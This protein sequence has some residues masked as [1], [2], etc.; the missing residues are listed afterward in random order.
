[1]N[2]GSK[3]LDPLYVPAI[4]N[5]V[6]QFNFSKTI[7]CPVQFTNDPL[8]YVES[9]IRY[10]L[11][12]VQKN[13]L[14]DLFS[15]DAE[16]TP[17]YKHAVFIGGMRGGKSVIGGVIGSF[18]LQKLLQ[19]DDP[20]TT[21]GQVPGQKFAAEFIATSEQ[22][23]KN[24]AYSAFEN[25]ILR[26]PWWKKYIAYLQEREATEGKETLF[27]CHERKLIFG[28][29]N[30]EAH[31]LHS[32]SSSIAGFTAFFV[33][34]DEMSRFD[35]GEGD[36]Q[37]KS[38]KRTAQA[39]FYTA[40]R[41]A[42]TLKKF[43][44]IL[45]ITS[46]MYETDFGMQLLYMAKDIEAGPSTR[47]IIEALRL[48][49]TKR[50]S[51][52]KG[53]HYA[54]WEA[55]PKT[56][57][58]PEGYTEDDFETEKSGNFSTFL[59]DYKAIPPSAISPFFD[60]PERIDKSV[61][62]DKIPVA[63]F[64]NEI[65]EDSVGSEVRKYIGK[66]IQILAGNKV[67]KYFICCD[68]GEVKD[69][70]VVAMGHGEVSDV[71]V[72]DGMGGYTDTKKYKIIIDLVE[73]WK[74]NKEDRITVSFQ[75]VEEVIRALNS[76]FYIDRV[77][78]DQWHST[79]SI[80]RL[81]SDGI[82]TTKLGATIEMYETMKILMYS[83]MVELPYNE[84]LLMELRQ[85]NVIKNK[86]IEHPGEGSKDM[87]DAIVRVIYSVYMDSIRDTVHG[88]FMLPKVE[89]LNTIRS[90][91]TAY[92][93]MK[94]DMMQEASYHYGIFGVPGNKKSVFGK[95]M[96]VQSNVIPNIGDNLLK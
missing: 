15:E 9:Y 61:N 41:A 66:R 13:V 75:N 4:T 88:Q 57:D 55:N 63:A 82:V 12:P 95:S 91:A 28:E 2:L 65:I 48:R 62:P 78:F 64:T 90:V 25:I 69:S 35:V 20:G 46:P 81:F 37:Q 70:F 52:I 33:C 3:I 49:Y 1:M 67:Q 68:Q 8:E 11:N 94:Q 83:G 27:K 84:T 58:N 72:Q 80:Q 38:E 76:Y 73:A 47:K 24:T 43:A 77:V 40:S 31:S 17:I 44:K 45:T 93:I 50:V 71:K 22:Q 34:F 56:E 29:K 14:I 92:E 96:I 18:L 53:Y 19:Y 5:G 42:K 74:P 10:K 16:G 51:N 30:V 59:R 6:P 32:N 26:T 39:V 7:R 21:L 86:K 36:V 23:S 54:T 79:E 85:L 89:R 87:A 60:L